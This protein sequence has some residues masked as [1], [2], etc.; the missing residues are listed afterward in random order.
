MPG[1]SRRLSVLAAA[2]LLSF[3]SPVLA[4]QGTI[5]AT[6]LAEYG[7]PLYAPDMPHWPYANPDA[8]KG[9]TVKLWGY[10]T[11][12][13]LNALILRGEAPRNVSMVDVGLMVSSG[14]ELDAAYPMIASHVTYAED[15]SWAVFTIRPEARWSDGQPI[16]ADDFVF[17]FDAIKAHGRPFSKIFFED[18]AKAEA[19]G[20]QQVKF[21][22]LSTG[23]KKPLLVAAGLA[24]IAK[25]WWTGA[26]GR[27]ISQPTITPYPSSGPYRFGAIEPGRMISYERVADWWGR[28]LPTAKGL[29]NFDTI[30]FDYYQDRDVAFE[31][32]LGGAFDF[33]Q[34][35]T[36]RHW[37]TGF[38]VP[39]VQDGRLIKTTFPD[40]SPKGLQGFYLNTRRKP[41]DDTRVRQALG[42]LFD[43]EWTNQNLMYG[44]YTRSKSF[45]PN[46][47]YAAPPLPDAAELALL[48]PFRAQLPPELFTQPVPVSSTDGSGSVRAQQ[49]QAL[50]LLREAGWTQKDGKLIDANGQQMRL[51]LLESSGALVR[52]IEP[53][54][55]NLRRIGIQADIRLLGDAA[56]YQRQLDQFAFDITGINATFYP[57]PGPELLSRFSSTDADIPGSGNFAGIRSPVVDALMQE[58]LA[59]QGNLPRLKIVT[60]ALDRVLMWGHFVIPNWYNGNHLV[61]YWNRLEHPTRLPKYGVGAVG[62]WDGVGVGFPDLWWAK[63]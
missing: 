37:A 15:V 14:D 58:L 47:E 45:F 48:E 55:Q 50:A 4:E 24:P 51:E 54:L 9:G 26:P 60:H 3:A 31:A 13:T 49:R 17:A 30:R 12:D 28:D 11:F 61:A 21:S 16:T 43:F 1:L 53:W 42:L 52:V 38:N 5:T 41:L 25:H 8:P 57:P 35:Y 33:Q 2:L 29:Y 6:A 20:R 34:I 32:F 39:A 40:A 46:S 59:A 7:T 23:R 10:G 27:D 36:S 63:P 22:F 56:N 62:G 44:L 18:I 19:Q